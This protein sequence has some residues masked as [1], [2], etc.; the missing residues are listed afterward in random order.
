MTGAGVGAGPWLWGLLQNSPAQVSAL[1]T[2]DMLLRA[3]LDIQTLLI[4][5]HQYQCMGGFMGFFKQ[6]LKST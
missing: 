5:H 2:P 4:V 3:A 1:W 6:Y